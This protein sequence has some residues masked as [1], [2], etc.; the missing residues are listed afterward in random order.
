M[1]ANEAMKVIKEILRLKNMRKDAIK[2]KAD[3]YQKFKAF[4]GKEQELTRQLN[5]Q[6]EELEQFG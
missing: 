4:L 1:V 3:H 5:E 6:L 2:W